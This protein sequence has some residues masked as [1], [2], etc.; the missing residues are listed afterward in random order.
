MRMHACSCNDVR[1]QGACILLH[2]CIQIRSLDCIGRREA[3]RAG[4]ALCMRQ[5]RGHTHAAVS[6]PA[7][8]SVQQ[9]Q[10]QQ[11]FDDD[12]AETAEPEQLPEWACS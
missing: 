8:V 6:L 7:C 12:E 4:L 11:G 2:I 3:G 5:A 9:L 10:F 1:C